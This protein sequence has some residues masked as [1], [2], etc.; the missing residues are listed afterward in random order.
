MNNNNKKIFPN[1]FDLIPLK[2]DSISILLWAMG[3]TFLSFSFR[4]LPTNVPVQKSIAILNRVSSLSWI[5]LKIGPSQGRHEPVVNAN[6]HGMS[7][8]K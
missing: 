8:C 3:D 7:W 5:T 1:D 2:E 4:P 6:G